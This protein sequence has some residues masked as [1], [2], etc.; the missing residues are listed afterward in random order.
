MPPKIA[1]AENTS[2]IAIAP[3][4]RPNLLVMHGEKGGVGKSFAAALAA[5]TALH[6]GLSVHIIETDS[7]VPDVA[8][9]F[10]NAPGAAVSAIALDRDNEASET[11]TSLLGGVEALI[12]APNPPAL[13]VINSPA[14]ASSVLDAYA[15]IFATVAQSLD[16][17]LTVGFVVDDS[18]AVLPRIE[19]SIKTGLLS[20]PTARRGLVYT[21]WRGDIARFPVATSSARASALATGLVE[22]VFPGLTPASMLETVRKSDSPI[23]DLLDPAAGLKIVDRSL[24]SRWLKQAEPLTDWLIGG[25]NG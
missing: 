5:S 22:H 23:Y 11:L 19:A 10:V 9:R 8:P 25:S 21:G 17:D 1:L 14:N 18:A 6:R 2:A 12:T 3:T 7:S 15:D 20:I 4:R 13:I 16:I 24:L